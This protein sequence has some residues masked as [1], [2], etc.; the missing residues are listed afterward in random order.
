MKVITKTPENFSEL[1]KLP[2][3]NGDATLEQARKL[4]SSLYDQQGKEYNNHHDLNKLR[5]RMAKQTTY[6]FSSTCETCETP[7][8]MWNTSWFWLD[9]GAMSEL[10]DSLKCEC[11][12]RQMCSTGCPCYQSGMPCIE[13]CSCA[14]PDILVRQPSPLFCSNLDLG[15]YSLFFLQNI[16]VQTP[17]LKISEGVEVSP[18]GNFSHSRFSKWPPIASVEL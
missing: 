13:L 11:G 16:V 14:A 9:T 12:V 2:G 5:T 8:D 3:T 18:L 6:Q 10:I 1:V 17:H 15:V 7:L 4:V